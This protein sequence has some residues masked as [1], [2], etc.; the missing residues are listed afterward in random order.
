MSG[1]GGGGGRET[2]KT[3][4]NWEIRQVDFL[5]ASPNISEKYSLE[6]KV[7]SNCCIKLDVHSKCKINRH[8]I[9]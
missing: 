7:G 5:S 3:K 1:G 4:E 6:I 2:N 9:Y 8:T